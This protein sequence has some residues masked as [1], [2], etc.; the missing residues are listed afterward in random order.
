MWAPAIAALVVIG[1]AVIGV[2]VVSAVDFIQGVVDKTTRSNGASS[3]DPTD[4]R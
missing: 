4:D 3:P 2:A 1:L